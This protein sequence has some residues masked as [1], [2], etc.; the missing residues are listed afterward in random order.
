MWR[1]NIKKT[2]SW[3]F[4]P[5]F[6]ISKRITPEHWLYSSALSPNPFK[7]STPL[8]WQDLHAPFKGLFWS[9]EGCLFMNKFNISVAYIPSPWPC[10]WDLLGNPKNKE[11]YFSQTPLEG[12]PHPIS[13]CKAYFGFSSSF[14]RQLLQKLHL[15]WEQQTGLCC[16]VKHFHHY[17]V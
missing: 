8:K 10:C 11:H 15:C 13:L 12:L 3:G 1:W 9:I 5:N 14:Q 17:A 6:Q 2:Q 4:F 7:S 16:G